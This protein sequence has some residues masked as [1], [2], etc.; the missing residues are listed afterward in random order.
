M[1][2]NYRDSKIYTIRCHDDPTL[3]YVGSTV[4]PLCKRFATHKSW[5]KYY[6]KGVNRPLYKKINEEYGG[7]WDNWYIE[8][9]EAYP[10]ANREELN[11]REGQIMRELNSVLNKNIAGRTVQESRKNWL[12]HNTEYH[13]QYYLQHAERLKEYA[14]KHYYE[15]KCLDNSRDALLA[16]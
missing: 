5:S 1:S 6:N 15:K 12:N 16:N 10:C 11:K 9:H 8:L 4:Q 13:K 3:I 2:I 7:N 14:K